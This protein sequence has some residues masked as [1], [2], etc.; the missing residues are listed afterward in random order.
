MFAYSSIEHA[1]L[2]AIGFG[3]GNVFGIYASLLHLLYHTLAKPLAFF[4]AGN[5]FLR[6]G[7]TKLSHVRGLARVAPITAGILVLASVTLMGL[8]PFGIFASE[9][10][11]L[12]AAFASHP[13]VGAV[14]LVFLVLSFI[15]TLRMVAGLLTGEPSAEIEKGEPSKAT[16]FPAIALGAL[17]LVLSIWL[18]LWFPTLFQ[19]I[20]I[21]FSS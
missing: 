13:F 1:G 12:L 19:N 18:P 20:I 14:V 3:L 4:A 6:Y 11:L 21:A 16:L 10:T 9:L 2:L 5:V 7:T 15:A 8:P 17:L